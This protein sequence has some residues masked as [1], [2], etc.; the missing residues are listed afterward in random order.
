MRLSL[1]LLT[2]ESFFAA[3]SIGCQ[4]SCKVVGVL[5]GNTLILL[6]AS[7]EELRI[8]LYGFECKEDALASLGS[9]IAFFGKTNCVYSL[10]THY[11]GWTNGVVWYDEPKINPIEELLNAGFV[12]HFKRYDENPQW[13]KKLEHIAKAT[14]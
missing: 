13:I 14:N 6:S 2:S 12:W 3:T 8:R 10:D 11:Y 7:H 9:V 1:T 5:D 4:F